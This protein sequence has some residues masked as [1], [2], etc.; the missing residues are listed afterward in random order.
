MP[1]RRKSNVDALELIKAY[2]EIS[3]SQNVPIEQTIQDNLPIFWAASDSHRNQLHEFD[4]R[5]YII[6]TS[7]TTIT[8][9]VGKSDIA[10]KVNEL[11]DRLSKLEN[12]MVEEQGK[13]KT[14]MIIYFVSF[15]VMNLIA[16][17][18]ILIWLK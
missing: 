6:E 10:S 17:I 8:E 1:I 3:R 12:K 13:I 9:R 4:K 2:I 16:L 18:L 7:I 11:N 15:V 14:R 5:I